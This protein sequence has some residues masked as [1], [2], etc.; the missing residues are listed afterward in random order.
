MQKP[1]DPEPYGR[2]TKWQCQKCKRIFYGCLIKSTLGI[3]NQLIEHVDES[4]QKVSLGVQYDFFY[5]GNEEKKILWI[6][7]IGYGEIIG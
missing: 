4:N 5:F 6:M 7:F 2:K 1:L 3:A